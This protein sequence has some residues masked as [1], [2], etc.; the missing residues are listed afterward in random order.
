MNRRQNAAED[1]LKSQV[2][3][4]KS[5]IEEAETNSPEC[6]SLNAC[7]LQH[8]WGRFSGQQAAASD[9]VKG[10]VGIG[11]LRPV[12]GFTGR[13]LPSRIIERDAVFA[14]GDS[15]RGRVAEERRFAKPVYG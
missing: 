7:R 15:E 1:D 6:F 14:A 3:Q 8:L 9:L 11:F 5:A 2:T 13:R 10:K 12:C 4:A